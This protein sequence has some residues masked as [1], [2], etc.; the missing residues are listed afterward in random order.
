[1]LEIADRLGALH[2][3]NQEWARAADAYARA[4]AALDWTYQELSGQRSRV[5]ELTTN[6]RLVELAV[7]AMAMADRADVAVLLLENG[8]TRELGADVA[9][10]SAAMGRLR[11][12]AP[13]LAAEL[14]QVQRRLGDLSRSG[15]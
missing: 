14:Q 15:R 3:E 11:T 7:H 9:R 8:R 1:M 4:I 12:V 5:A 10:D 6:Y 13:A 2:S